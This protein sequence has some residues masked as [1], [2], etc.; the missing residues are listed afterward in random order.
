[1]SGKT[2][3]RARQ[4]ARSQGPPQRRRT[5][6]GSL[7]RIPRRWLYGGLGAAAVVVV[8]ALVVASQLGGSEAAPRA[9]SGNETAALLDGIPQDGATL[10]SPDAPVVLYEFADLQC[11]FCQRWNGGVLPALVD[12]YVRDGRLRIVFGGVAFIGPD[13]E[14]ALRTAYA[15][16]GQ[17]RLWHV[18]DLLYRHQGPENDGWVTEDL[19]RGIGNAVPGLETG[20]MLDERDSEAVDQAIGDAAGRWSGAGLNST[21][22]FLI[23]PAGGALEVLQGGSDDPAPFREAIDRLL[24][25]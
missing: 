9:I 7:A 25:A 5:D 8:V 10:G 17:D 24:G 20:R 15:A 1:M 12:E 22:S 14:T 6:E 2:A 19:L 11:P 4:T 13:S 18:V 3:R 23:G 16:G 21:P